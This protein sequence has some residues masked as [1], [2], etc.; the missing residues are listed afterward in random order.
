MVDMI[1]VDIYLLFK[2]LNR[3]IKISDIDILNSNEDRNSVLYK[4]NN[5]V[6]K[7]EQNNFIKNYYPSIKKLCSIDL[8]Y[9]CNYRNK[10][11]INPNIFYYDFIKGNKLCDFVYHYGFKSIDKKAIINKLTKF[12]KFYIN[13]DT[14]IFD[15]KIKTF[16]VDNDM[17]DFRKK[18]TG[19]NSFNKNLIQIYDTCINKQKK[20]NKTLLLL[21]DL[22]AHNIIISDKNNV[23]LIDMSDGLIIGNYNSFIHRY[24]SL[25]WLFGEKVVD[26]AIKDC[27]INN[28]NLLIKELSFFYF[29]NYQLHVFELNSP[30]ERFERLLF[31]YKCSKICKKLIKS[32]T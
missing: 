25:L 27:N 9:I 31:K 26:K 28:D 15:K 6:L 19:N 3:N 21:K 14:N 7:S 20:T 24:F 17:I 16:E 13:I 2:N 22:N 1:P 8:K 18:I 12:I 11:Y 5:I 10:E 29:Y 4:A 23:K 30:I 32:L